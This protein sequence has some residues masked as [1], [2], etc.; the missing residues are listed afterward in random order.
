MHA[1]KLDQID[2]EIL[3]ILQLNGRTKRNELAERVGLTNPAISDRLRKLEQHGVIQK[4]TTIVD[5]EKVQ[6]G[7]M[8][9]I[10]VMVESSTYFQQVIVNA[11]K[12]DEI[13]ECHAVTGGGSHLLKVR[14]QS[15]ITLE[16]LL[17]QIQAWE[18]VK[19]TITN[20]VL[21]SPKET[22]A[23]PLDHLLANPN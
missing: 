7:V 12:H 13:L 11:E 16:K 15:T 14:T 3:K 19:N 18:G 20:V 2:L 23:L 22:T 9:F 21:S 6:L 5:A 4:Y 10:F 17:S 8:A 1:D